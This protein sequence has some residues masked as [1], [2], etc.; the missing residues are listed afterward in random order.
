MDSRCA[1]NRGCANAWPASRSTSRWRACSA[2]RPPGSSSRAASRRHN[3]RWRR[4]SSASWR[5]ASPTLAPNC[6][7]STASCIPTSPRR[8]CTG[9]CSGSI[10]PRRCWP[11][12]AA[13]TKCSATS[14]PCWATACRASERA[15]QLSPTPEQQ[16]ILDAV[17]RFCREQVTPERLLAWERE[18]R[19][20]DT[21]CWRAITDLGW[22][23]VGLPESCGRSGLGLGEVACLLQACGRGLVPRAVINAVRGGWAL[24]QLDAQAPELAQVA[25][26]DSVVALAFDERDGCDPGRFATAVQ[27][28]GDALR[29]S[30]EKWYVAN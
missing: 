15:M 7:A 11:S 17:E 3:R 25:R 13:P 1:S 18:P 23:G 14:S 2:S 16:D 20:I 26:G 29:V 10:A 28:S 5:S 24:A 8:T 4:C 9:V 30:G 21:A 6:S 22:F 12:A 27:G 19:R